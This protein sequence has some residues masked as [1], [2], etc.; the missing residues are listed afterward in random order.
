MTVQDAPTALFPAPRKE[1]DNEFVVK[2]Y[3]NN[4]GYEP[5]EW[6]MPELKAAIFLAWEL[7]SKQPWHQ[8][9]VTDKNGR[10]YAAFNA[11]W[12]YERGHRV[13]QEPA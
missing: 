10:Q 5:F 9:F 3:P 6:P 13:G 1:D 12:D 4:I 2:G 7:A 8:V 11:L